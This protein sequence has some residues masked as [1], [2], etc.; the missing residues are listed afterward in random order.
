MSQPQHLR[1]DDIVDIVVRIAAM[2]LMC[3]LGIFSI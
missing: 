3:S 1:N 2:Y